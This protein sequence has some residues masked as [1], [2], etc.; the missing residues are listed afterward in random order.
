MFRYLYHLDLLPVLLGPL[1]FLVLEIV[2][3]GDD[4]AKNDKKLS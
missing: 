4:Y 1:K 3:I 2:L